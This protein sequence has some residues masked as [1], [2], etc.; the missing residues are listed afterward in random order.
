MYLL[1]NLN[2]LLFPSNLLFRTSQVPFDYLL[3]FSLSQVPLSLCLSLSLPDWLRD[4]RLLVSVQYLPGVFHGLEISSS[5]FVHPTTS[6]R[7]ASFLPRGALFSFRLCP[8]HRKGGIF[9]PE[10]FWLSERKAHKDQLWTFLSATPFSRSPLLDGVSSN[11]ISS[12]SLP[13]LSGLSGSQGCLPSYPHPSPFQEM[14]VFLCFFLHLDFSALSFGL[15]TAARV[16]TKCVVCVIVF[17]KIRWFR[18]FLI[19][20]TCSFKLPPLKLCFRISSLLFSCCR[21]GLSINCQKSV[22]TPSQDHVSLGC[23]IQ[24]IPMLASLPASKALYRFAFFQS[25]LPLDSV[26]ARDFLRVLRF[27]A[28]NIPMLPLARLHMRKLQWYLKSV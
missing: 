26:T 28:S 24:S 9:I 10:C 25:I 19:W 21:V 7:T 11:F 5:L 17:S 6:L 15:T 12:S 22:S 8:L 4:N 2:R 3:P 13:G 23:R 1:L 20:K 16:F 18:S 27:M 14:F